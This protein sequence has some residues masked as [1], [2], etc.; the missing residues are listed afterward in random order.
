MTIMEEITN[1]SVAEGIKLARGI[2]ALRGNHAE[3][4]LSETQL[5]ANLALAFRHGVQ[6]AINE[7]RPLTIAPEESSEGR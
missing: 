5:A 3:I 7:L 2:F 6:A 4:H 1:K